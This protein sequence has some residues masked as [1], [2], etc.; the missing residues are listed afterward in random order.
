M[1]NSSSL[2]LTDN[3]GPE[4]GIIVIAVCC[5][6]PSIPKTSQPTTVCSALTTEGRTLTALAEA[7]EEGKSRPDS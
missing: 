2:L 6:P 4:L 7:A 1:W 5:C 3:E